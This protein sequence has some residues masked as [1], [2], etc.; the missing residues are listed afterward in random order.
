M[1]DLLTEINNCFT[2]PSSRL[3]LLM[4]LN[5]YTSQQTF[6][7]SASVLAT[8]P[9]M[10]SIITSLLLDSSSTVCNTGL[11]VLVKLLPIF[12]VQAS[13]GLKRLLP[14]F[15]AILVRI[16]CWKERPLFNFQP[17]ASSAAQLDGTSPHTE[18]DLDY[19][20]QD[21]RP[22]QVRPDLG[23]ERLELTFD[24][25]ASS[26]PSPRAFFTRLYYLFPRNT[27][28]FLRE[29]V[30]YLVES[31]VISPYTVSWEKVLD[32]VKIRTICE[33]CPIFIYL[34]GTL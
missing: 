29:P 34:S 1:Q 8:H 23:W 25:T 31:A 28:R 10:S 4:L 12:A 7:T 19:E 30:I 13:E 9:L 24:A 20:E 26:A 11:T 22:L 21:D 6:Q 33:V 27:L 15:F 14:Q 32:E 2:T 16:I 17:S 18:I 3:Q 5:V